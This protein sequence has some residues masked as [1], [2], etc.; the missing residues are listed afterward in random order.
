[1][2]APFM[3][4][5]KFKNY[6]KKIKIYRIKNSGRTYAL[7]YGINKATSKYSMIMM[8]MIILLK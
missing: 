5:K 3:M 8:M 2:M 4:L 7:F 1:M 6:G